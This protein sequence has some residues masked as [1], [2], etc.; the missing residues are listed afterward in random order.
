VNE[1]LAS[2]HR[3]RGTEHPEDFKTDDAQ[4]SLSSKDLCCPRYCLR[5]PLGSMRW[6][7]KGCESSRV[8]ESLISLR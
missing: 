8:E 3:V 7:K 6:G 4:V 5:M 2:S 1:S